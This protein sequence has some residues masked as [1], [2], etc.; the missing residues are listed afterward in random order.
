MQQENSI[1]G[2]KIPSLN[3][4][5]EKAV[6]SFLNSDEDSITLVQ[7]PPGTGKTT[8]QC[9]TICRWLEQPG[10]TQPLVVCAPTKKAVS[11]LVTRFLQAAITSNVNIAVLGSAKK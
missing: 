9:A 1:F 10:F 3:A 6:A 2:L 7:G 5:Q 8:L 11:V 4:T